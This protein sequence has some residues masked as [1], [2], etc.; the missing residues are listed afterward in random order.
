[1]RA[2]PSY[3]RTPSPWQLLAQRFGPRERRRPF[4]NILRL[5]H[6]SALLA[7]DVYAKQHMREVELYLDLPM[8]D[9]DMLDMRPIESIVEHGYDFT[10]KKLAEDGVRAAVLGVGLATASATDARGS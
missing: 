6:R 9:V 3:E 2:H 1:V 7:S 5:V 8:D 4:P 10:R